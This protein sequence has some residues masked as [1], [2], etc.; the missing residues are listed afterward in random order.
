M[1]EISS[2]DIAKLDDEQLRAVVARLCEAEL[3]SRGLSTSCVTWGGN[4]NAPD[5]GID[6]H[7]ALPPDTSIEGY[8]PRVDTGF[9][10][11]QEDMP[12]SRIAAEMRPQN[13]LR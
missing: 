12:A 4:Q 1:F 9:Q 10:V 3:R 7:V 2:K 11:K 13:A 8:I 6:V 5:G